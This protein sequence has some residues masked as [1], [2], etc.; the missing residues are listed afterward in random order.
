VR[1]D[2]DN[3][4]VVITV[5]DN[6]PGIGSEDMA[7]LFTPYFTTK[8]RGHGLGLLIVRR[9][10]REHGGDIRIESRE[11]HGTTVCLHLPFA[12]PRVHLLAAPEGV[13]T[14]PPKP[15]RGKR[16]PRTPAPGKVIDLD[17]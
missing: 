17:P 4:G 3:H 8:S 7:R 10:L 1:S 9:I 13:S 5:A 15:A 16:K 11:G 14:P 2:Y 6:G 12:T